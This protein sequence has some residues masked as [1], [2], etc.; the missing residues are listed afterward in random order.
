MFGV[1]N[2]AFFLNNTLM[3]SIHQM[4]AASQSLLAIR[5][6]SKSGM[7]RCLSHKNMCCMLLQKT[8]VWFPATMWQRKT[9]LKT[10]DLRDLM[11]SPALN[12]HC[13]NTSNKMPA[14][15]FQ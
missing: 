10:A 3:A 15:G 5:N 6:V 2:M 4:P 8:Q 12:R 14:L 11:P 1:L 9:E 13:T 7:K